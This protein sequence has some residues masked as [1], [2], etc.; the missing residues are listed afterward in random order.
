MLVM[1]TGPIPPNATP[2][3]ARRARMRPKLRVNAM[4]VPARPNRTSADISIGLRPYLSA[5]TPASG[6]MT[7]DGALN[8][9]IRRLRSAVVVLSGPVNESS[10]GET[11][12]DPS[13]GNM[14]ATINSWKSR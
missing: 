14:F 3:R 5:S 12:P 2:W 10:I 8:T 4:A 13:T 11:S 1:M 7:I 6:I 9:D